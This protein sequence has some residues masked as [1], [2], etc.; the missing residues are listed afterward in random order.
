MLPAELILGD[1]SSKKIGGKIR[2][3][4]LCAAPGSKTAQLLDGLH[5]LKQDG[6]IDDALLV[7]NDVDK[8]RAFQIAQRLRVSPAA[9]ML[10]VTCADAASENFP[11]QLYN[12]IGAKFDYILADVPCSGDGTI[13][14]N[15]SKLHSFRPELGAQNSKLQKKLL[16]NGLKLLERCGVGDGGPGMLVYS[17]CSLNPAENERVLESCLGAEGW[18]PRGAGGLQYAARILPGKDMGG[19]FVAQI[20]APKLN[21]DEEESGMVGLVEER[22]GG[23]TGVAP[24]LSHSQQEW[25]TLMDE[26]LAASLD[27]L[28]SK[29]P[30]VVVL[31]DESENSSS[32]TAYSPAAADFVNGLR[33]RG[34]IRAGAA[35]EWRS[36]P[37]APQISLVAA[38]IPLL[39]QH[40]RKSGVDH[41]KSE[42]PGGGD[43]NPVLL[44]QEGLLMLAPLLPPNMVVEVSQEQYLNW[45]E[46]SGLLAPSL[47]EVHGPHVPLVFIEGAVAADVLCVRI[48]RAAEGRGGHDHDNNDIYLSVLRGAG[49]GFWPSARPQVLHRVFEVLLLNGPLGEERRHR[50]GKNKG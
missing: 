49:G 29:D 35:G 33:C 47:E 32:L 2:I 36:P 26:R 9:A 20:P 27:S 18:N 19:F 24:A 46:G 30:Q 10:V 4:D 16:R 3:L 14:K 45:Y 37:G 1:I 38:G 41:E 31:R 6:L 13:R 11:T 28:V 22:G 12:I 15:T 43:E 5:K 21:A 25:G 23:P 44:F 34:G 7:A 40:S 50:K 8:Y 39:Q 17:T 42:N 48:P